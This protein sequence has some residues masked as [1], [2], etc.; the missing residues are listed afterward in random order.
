MPPPSDFATV[1]TVQANKIEKHTYTGRVLSQLYMY[2]TA[3]QSCEPTAPLKKSQSSRVR[4]LKC[5]HVGSKNE[6][7]GVHHRL[8][9]VIFEIYEVLGGLGR[10]GLELRAVLHGSWAVWQGC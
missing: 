9:G 3:Q 5:S 2:R 1:G 7:R 4:V 8:L 6:P 10:F